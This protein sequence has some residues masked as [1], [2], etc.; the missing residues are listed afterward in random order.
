MRTDELQGKPVVSIAEG[1]K[2][3]SV[4]EVLLDDSYLQLAALV[5]GGGGLFGGHRQAVAYSAVRG[6]G[7]DAVMVSGRDAVQEVVE[8]S[9]LGVTHRLGELHQEVM[10]ESGVHLGRVEAVEFDPQTGGLT[11][12]WFAPSGA[13]GQEGNGQGSVSREDIVNV[14]EKMV[15]VRQTAPQR[16]SRE[17]QGNPAPDRGQLVGQTPTN[18]PVRDA[19]Q[20]TADGNQGGISPSTR[21]GFPNSEQPAADAA[22]GREWPVEET[23]R[24]GGRLGAEP[25]T[26]SPGVIGDPAGVSSN[27]EGRS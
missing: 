17:L 5:I 26:R 18:P 1:T 13:T 22:V 8:P 12:L 23:V 11:T 19:I 24:N 20:T 6:I 9:S 4:D 16:G 2:L 27:G 7:P 10:S 3:G 15:V 21:E 14:A 25:A